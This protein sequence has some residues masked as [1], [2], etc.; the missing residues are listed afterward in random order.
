MI[1]RRK[2]EAATYSVDGAVA[3]SI[4]LVRK[5]FMNYEYKVAWCPYCDQGWVEIVQDSITEKLLLLCSECDTVWEKP[6]DIALDKPSTGHLV[7]NLVKKP[8]LADIQAIGW[9]QNIIRD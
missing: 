5:Y 4:K 8:V 2:K 6:E 3:A 9:D 7:I 1:R